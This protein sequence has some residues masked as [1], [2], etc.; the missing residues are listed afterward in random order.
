MALQDYLSEARD[1]LCDA[2]APQRVEQRPYYASGEEL[3][4]HLR[5]IA[6]EPGRADEVLQRMLPDT[7]NIC[8]VEPKARIC[9]HC[10]LHPMTASPVIAIDADRL[11]ANDWCPW[12]AFEEA[13]LGARRMDPMRGPC[14]HRALRRITVANCDAASPADVVVLRLPEEGNLH[15][16]TRLRP[17]EDRRLLQHQAT[18]R[19]VAMLMHTKNRRGGHFVTLA[20]DPAVMDHSAWVCFD[21]SAN[22]GVGWSVPPPTGYDT[23]AGPVGCSSTPF[24]P[25]VVMYVRVPDAGA[26]PSASAATR[27]DGGGSQDLLDTRESAQRKTARAPDLRGAGSSEAGGGGREGGGDAARGGGGEPARRVRRRQLA[28]STKA[29]QYCGKPVTEDLSEH[30]T[31]VGCVLGWP[32]Q[33]AVRHLRPQLSALCDAP[34]VGALYEMMSEAD[35]MGDGS[36]WV[37]ILLLWHGMAPH[38]VTPVGRLRSTWR[39]GAKDDTTSSE[40]LR[41]RME[42]RVADLALREAMARWMTRNAWARRA[43]QVREG[44]VARQP[45]DAEAADAVA[46]RRDG[47]PSY[48]AG[49][50]TGEGNAWG[51]FGGDAE[52]V[53]AADVLQMAII[54]VPP[55]GLRAGENARVE[56][57]HPGTLHAPGEAQPRQGVNRLMSVREA[58]AMCLREHLPLRVGLS[59]GGG[60][61]ARHWHALV[62]TDDRGRALF[63]QVPTGALDVMQTVNQR[64]EEAL[65]ELD[66]AGGRAQLLHLN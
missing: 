2:D 66:A 63:R 37:Y 52:Y 36:C 12:A 44:G 22:R 65:R 43:L 49:V 30:V 39:L 38:A 34:C 31:C 56:V 3:D 33:E 46:D 20:R 23:L 8:R 5:Q 59:E 4:A 11:E 54:S 25:V 24:W 18:Y 35:V 27:S 1:A 21:A 41:V 53:A 48:R 55:S 26:A 60:H 19:V 51:V 45:T 9:P 7:P 61:R 10:G 6:T 57:A 50:F 62:P 16:Q 58:L 32:T 15:Y 40:A 14:G 64:R 17:C 28:D 47:V 42:D 13:M 29:C